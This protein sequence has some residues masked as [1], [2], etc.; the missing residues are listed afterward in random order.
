VNLLGFVEDVDD[1]D[2]VGSLNWTFLPEYDWTY[3]LKNFMK[4]ISLINIIIKIT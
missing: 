3:F 4:D 1:V 2:L